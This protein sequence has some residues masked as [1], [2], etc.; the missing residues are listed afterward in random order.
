[1]NKVCQSCGM[2][3]EDASLYGANADGSKNDEYCKFCYPNGAFHKPDE[4]M[5]EMIETCVSF[6]VKDGME[7]EQ[8]REILEKSLPHLKRWKNEA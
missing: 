6:M 7:E 4:T 5:E 3:M 1:M 2:P 8:A